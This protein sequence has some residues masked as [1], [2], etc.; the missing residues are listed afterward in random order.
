[1][2]DK[3]IL[4]T[5][6]M[7]VD[8]AEMTSF[9]FNSLSYKQMCELH[10]ITDSEYEEKPIPF[11]YGKFDLV[12]LFHSFITQKD[13]GTNIE[14]SLI[15]DMKD[16]FENGCFSPDWIEKSVETEVEPPVPQRK[17]LSVLLSELEDIKNN[18]ENLE[19]EQWYLAKLIKYH[20]EG[21]A[22]T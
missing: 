5:D 19:A 16:I 18:I 11:K 15:M 21:F 22:R 4:D 6:E 3:K 10:K 2:K 8:Y 9:N 12:D 7:M 20:N 14:G 17:E 1:M 13:Q